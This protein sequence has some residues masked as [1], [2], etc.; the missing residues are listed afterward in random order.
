MGQLLTVRS[1]DAVVTDTCLSEGQ[2]RSQESVEERVREPQ[3]AVDD[4]DE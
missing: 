1:I 3:G 2:V 4:D